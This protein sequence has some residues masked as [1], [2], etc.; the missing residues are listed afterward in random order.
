MVNNHKSTITMNV[1]IFGKRKLTLEDIRGSDFDRFNP[2]LLPV[3][4]P[5][6]SLRLFIYEDC[7]CR[8]FNTWNMSR[9]GQ[10]MSL[11]STI[12]VR[13]LKL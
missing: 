10:I 13:V 9:N 1:N 5:P 8:I 2:E 4:Q 6:K 3:T 11:Q 12:R 7:F